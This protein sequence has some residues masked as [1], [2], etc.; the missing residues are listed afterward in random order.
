MTFK[1]NIDEDFNNDV[2]INPSKLQGVNEEEI[3]RSHGPEMW[4]WRR[5]SRRRIL[6][7]RDD[8][9]HPEELL[10]DVLVDLMVLF[11]FMLREP[12]GKHYPF[13]TLVGQI[14]QYIFLYVILVDL[15]YFLNIVFTNLLAHWCRLYHMFR[16]LGRLL[17]KHM[18]LKFV[19]QG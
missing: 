3:K 17:R 14:L 7:K 6:V 8:S 12:N 2:G 18:L 13:A 11:M 15:C 10:L 19:P 16:A 5:L 9:I 4:F 1:G